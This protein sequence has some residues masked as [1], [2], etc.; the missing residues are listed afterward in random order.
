M[1]LFIF[2]RSFSHG[3]FERLFLCRILAQNFKYATHILKMDI[4]NSV[5]LIGYPMNKISNTKEND[6]TESENKAI[7]IVGRRAAP[8]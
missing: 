8:K 2:R 1:L 6:I 5:R 7:L 4:I 3:K